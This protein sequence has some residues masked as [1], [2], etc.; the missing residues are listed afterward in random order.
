M[1]QAK[2]PRR[3]FFGLLLLLLFTLIGNAAAQQ[4]CTPPPPGLVSWWP[5]D[6]N[7]ND[8]QDHNPGTLA[9]GATFTAGQV[10]QA[11][12]FDGLDDFV[13]VPDA[14]SLDVGTADFSLDAWIK[15]TSTGLQNIVDKRVDN[16][17][18]SINGYSLFTFGGFLSF[19][20]ADSVGAG[21]TNFFSTAL[22]ADG[23][24][25]HVAVTVD[26]DSATGGKLY[27]DGVVVLTFD[28]TL[29]PGT[30]D[31]SGDF[32][33]GRIA[34]PNVGNTEAFFSGLIDEVEI[35]NR[36]LTAGEI[37][38]IVNAGNAGKCRTC[39]P[40]PA[41][42]VSWWPGDDNAFD[43]A[44]NNDG[45]LQNHATFAPGVVS[46][47]FSFDGVDDFVEIADAANLDIPGS[48]TVDAW[49]K[50]D[51]LRPSG[52]HNIISKENS[53]LPLDVNYNLHVLNNRLFFAVTFNAAA[54]FA[55]GSGGC[56]AGGC[57]V[58]GSTDLDTAAFH[59]V[60]GVYDDSAK[61]MKVYLDGAL[62]G[63]ATFTTT[64]SPQTNNQNV[65]IGKRNAFS[66]GTQFKGLIDEVEI[67]NRALSQA[68]IQAIVRADTAGKCKGCAPPPSGLLTWLPANGNAE[69]VVDANDGTLQDGATFNSGIVGQAFSF[70]GVSSV[71][72]TNPPAV[73]NLGSWTYD[74]WI[75]VS[76]F[77]NGGI[78]DG[79]GSYFV[80]RTA[81]TQN[82][83]DLKAVDN[84]FAFQIRYDDGTGLG[85]PI[86]GSINLG[87]WTHIAMVRE[88]GVNFHLYVNGQLVSSSPDT[89]GSLTP[90]TPKLGHHDLSSLAG[91][92]GLIDEF[93][94]FDRDLSGVEI[95]ALFE[96][97]SLGKCTSCSHGFWKNHTNAWGPTGFSPGQPVNSMS[98][99]TI[100]ASLVTD[101][102]LGSKTLLEALIFKGGSGVC[103]GA[104]ILL[105]QAV[106]ALLNAA[107]PDLAYPRTEAEVIADVNAAL[108]SLDRSTMLDL[109]EE[110]DADNN[111]LCPL[112]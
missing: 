63:T 104:Q 33:I 100:P 55:S 94:I 2:M 27:V 46:Q 1:K 39:A 83:A 7:A 93:E 80:D 77:T 109:A 23:V 68:E 30:L 6:G 38:A 105:R 4:T 103:G 92:V 29:R 10:G 19:Q 49:I 26:R 56:D 67:F 5:A 37:A 42:L 47:A 61:T 99:F 88:F 87:T 52:V 51:Q 66:A 96:A 11:F 108:A 41:D 36:A 3:V 8:I 106:A 32:R 12:S 57:F 54:A 13:S 15:T 74:L 90:P 97:G 35:Y 98:T 76:S 60:A 16:R 102:G 44:D 71:T 69:D 75:N 86:G 18:V 111:L 22:V 112:D 64:G 70:D 79:L 81:E 43:I 110:L 85:G 73:S 62:D 58:T 78:G 34:T 9:N 45:T 17:P 40:P 84:Q 25:H 14:P 107:H 21:F 31:N 101:C 95:R 59:H 65:R 50:L 48:L 82:L 72:L 53:N 89:G 28:P 24:F 20:M 91:F